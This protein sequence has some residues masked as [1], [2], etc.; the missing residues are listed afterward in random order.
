MTDEERD[1][2]RNVA[3]AHLLQKYRTTGHSTSAI[4]RALGLHKGWGSDSKIKALRRK[5]KDLRREDPGLR[6][7]IFTQ[8]TATHAA[9][10]EKCKKDEFETFEF[11]GSSSATK[12]DRQIRE[13]QA[14]DDDNSSRPA[15]FVITLRAGSVG[16]TLT[17][18]SHCFL[19][20]P[21][22]DPATEV[23]AAGRIH[24]LGQT[25]H[26][27]VTKFVHSNSPEENILGVHREIAA[28]RIKIV[29]N[30]VPAAAVRLL[31][32]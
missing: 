12:R 24:R 4:S 30:H 22:L 26:V 23:Q 21:A 16:I 18:A 28:G 1:E 3:K 9:I 20:E 15:V 7:V 10:V 25:K 8:Y 14:T 13:F 19:M 5:L 11:N 6:A 2:C 17:A 29:D 31:M 32:A 27:H